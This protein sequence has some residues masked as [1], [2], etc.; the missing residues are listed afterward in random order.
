ML[1]LLHKVTFKEQ[2]LSQNKHSPK[3]EPWSHSILV[4]VI[5]FLSSKW[6]PC[7]QKWFHTYQLVS[8]PCPHCLLLAHGQMLALPLGTYI[9]HMK[10]FH[11]A[12]TLNRA[13]TENKLLHLST[14]LIVPR[15]GINS[16]KCA[17]LGC[18]L[19]V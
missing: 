8:G 4:C 14:T 2:G 7:N 12:L 19:Q 13:N 9:G 15:T 1:M 16:P 10:L 18:F 6:Q 3:V 5:F 11:H 17:K